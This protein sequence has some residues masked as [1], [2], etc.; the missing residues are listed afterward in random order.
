MKKAL[1]ICLTFL[2]SLN[3]VSCSGTPDVQTNVPETSTPTVT[4]QTTEPT[5]EKTTE[6]ILS[7]IDVTGKSLETAK[8]S[9]EAMGFVV[10]TKEEF[11]ETVPNGN[12]ISQIP[13]PENNL[14]LKMGDLVTLTVSKGKPVDT[15]TYLDTIAYVEFINENPKNTFSAFTGQDCQGNECTRAV[16]F[17]IDSEHV[18]YSEETQATKQ[19]VYKIY[20]K[21]D[22]KYKHFISELTSGRNVSTVNIRMYADDKLIYGM[23]VTEET[24]SVPLNLDVS[25]VDILTIE[26][27]TA[28][29]KYSLNDYISCIILNNAYFE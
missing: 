2:L 3:F 11:D 17:C 4:E 21:L 28:F 27:S 19:A 29:Y 25:D 24:S 13:V 1:L 5:T 9:L 7:V 18:S 20:Y 12:V 23:G 16:K 8:A 26:I 6:E 14:K 10:Q 15:K 22:K